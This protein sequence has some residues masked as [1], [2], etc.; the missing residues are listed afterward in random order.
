MNERELSSCGVFFGCRG[1]VSSVSSELFMCGFHLSVR[2][3]WL[4]L[5]NLNF[6]HLGSSSGVVEVFAVNESELFTCG[7]PC[8]CN[9]GVLCLQRMDVNFLRGVSS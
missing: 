9:Y 5:T 2:R 7:F 6:L 3:E 4:E 1:S 8:L